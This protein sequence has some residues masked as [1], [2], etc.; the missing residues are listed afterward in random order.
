MDYF[1]SFWKRYVSK[2][3]ERARKMTKKAKKTF[4]FK[5]I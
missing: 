4:S 5:I 2:T 1:T 3:F